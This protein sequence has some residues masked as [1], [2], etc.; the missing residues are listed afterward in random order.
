[1]L[2]CDAFKK[3]VPPFGTTH[4]L[5]IITVKHSVNFYKNTKG[6]YSGLTYDLATEFAREL[7]LKTRFIVMQRPDQA[8][9]ALQAQQGHIAM[10]LQI[11]DSQLIRFRLG[12]VYQQIQHQ[13]AYNKTQPKPA[14]ITHLVG[15]TTKIPAG[16][17]YETRLNNIKQQLPDLEWLTVETSSDHLLVKLA[18]DVITATVADSLQIK[19]AKHFYPNLRVA[20]NLGEATNSHW[21]F[22]KFS[23]RAL[24]NKTEQFFSRI[25]RDGTL[26]RLLDRY[27][28]HLHRLE[29]ADIRHFLDNMSAILPS[30]REHFYQ[31]EALTDIDWRLI[32]ALSYQESLWDPL[33]TSRTGVRGIMM[34]TKDTAKRMQVVNRLDAQ[35]SIL[36]GARYLQL[37]KKRLPQ[38]ITE[39]DRTWIALAAYNQGYGHIIDAR[40]LA[41]RINL[42]P[43]LWIDLKKTLPLLSKKKYFDTLKHGRTR[44]GEAVILTESVRAYY[45]I[46]KKYHPP[47]SPNLPG[48][49]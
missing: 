37:L 4:E 35:Q 13:I 6:G 43:D 9:A 8:L 42:K 44:G 16:T 2:G 38:R 26:N 14:D 17:I 28:G 23:E 22:S 47:L 1:M 21:I 3:P 29:E 20:F 5:V 18:E 30:L 41:R 32:A 31:A 48:P 11:P 46:M 19:R 24:I 25:K 15:K 7:G 39:P 33:A 12:P 45:D 27:N 40:T 34:L 49:Y 10:G 36:A